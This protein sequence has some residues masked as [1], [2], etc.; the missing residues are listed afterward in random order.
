VKVM[1]LITLTTAILAAHSPWC[2]GQASDNDSELA[3]GLIAYA[4]PSIYQG[5]SHNEGLL[6][7]VEW[8]WQNWFFRDYSLGSYLAGGD[9][10]YLSAAISFDAFGD[11]KRGGSGVL[12]DMKKLDDIYTAEVSTGWFGSLGYLAL[13]YWQD[14]SDNHGGGAAVVSYGY[15]LEL[16]KWRID[17]HVSLTYAGSQ[18]AR[19]YVGVDADEAKAGRPEYRPGRSFQYQAGVSLSRFFGESNQVLIGLNHR[20]LSSAVYKSPIVDRRHTWSVS[21]GYVYVF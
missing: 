11:V 7:Y 5:G 18:V 8:E 4:E 12:E 17:P 9:N 13:S 15:P 16:W 20:R 14:I 19:Y 21:A 1:P 3:I 6:T 10:W 2:W